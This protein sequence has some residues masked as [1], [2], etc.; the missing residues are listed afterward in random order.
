MGRR[1]P[2]TFKKAKDCQSGYSASSVTQPTKHQVA[3][4]LWVMTHNLRNAGL[5]LG[6]L[7]KQLR[8]KNPKWKGILLQ[9]YGH[10]LAS[11]EQPKASCINYADT[12]EKS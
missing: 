10:I 8:T 12:I 5:P 6:P 2:G 9:Y 3:T 7:Q 1:L 11:K 4:Y